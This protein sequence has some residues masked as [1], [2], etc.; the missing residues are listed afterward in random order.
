MPSD[1]ELERDPRS[2]LYQQEEEK[3]VSL[4]DGYQNVYN[5]IFF[6]STAAIYSPFQL[7]YQAQNTMIVDVPSEPQEEATTTQPDVSALMTEK[8]TYVLSPEQLCRTWGIGLP[9]AKRTFLSTTQ[10]GIRSTLFP[11]I[12][13]RYP[14]GNRPL[15]YRHLPHQVF[16]DTLK[17]QIISLRGNKCSNIYATDF[18]WSRNFPMRKESEV[19]ETLD[20]FFNWYG[21]P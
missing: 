12:E 14:T 9:A 2:D 13:R 20:L 6:V 18:G 10:R 19:H 21:V 15:R 3:A 8:S 17:S 1:P 7:Y 4:L 16:Y 5:R 11:N